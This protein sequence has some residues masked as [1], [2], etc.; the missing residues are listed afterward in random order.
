VD[1]NVMF[2]KWKGSSSDGQRLAASVR[3][4]QQQ[5][6][7]LKQS[8]KDAAAKVNSTKAEIDSL[9]RR[10]EDKREAAAVNGAQQLAAGGGSEAGGGEGSPRVL[11]SERFEIV[12]QLKV[13]KARWVGWICQGWY[14]EGVSASFHMQL[15]Q[16]LNY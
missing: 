13:V 8:I 10:R 3:D 7:E 6:K 2:L 16:T 9:L 15:T 1:L 14:E 4:C 11:D 5:L 12:Q